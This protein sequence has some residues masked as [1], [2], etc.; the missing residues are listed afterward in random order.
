MAPRVSARLARPRRRIL[1]NGSVD[2]P[3]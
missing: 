3:L 1:A 2:D